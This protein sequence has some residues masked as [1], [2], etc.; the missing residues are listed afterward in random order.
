MDI[1]QAPLA[2]LEIVRALT[3]RLH[4]VITETQYDKLVRNP[5]AFSSFLLAIAGLKLQSKSFY[6]LP[7]YTEPDKTHFFVPYFLDRS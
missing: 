6:D 4:L 7:H 5:R 1:N 3:H 2:R